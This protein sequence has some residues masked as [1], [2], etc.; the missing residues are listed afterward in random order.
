MADPIKVIF[1]SI[2][3]ESSAKD[4]DYYISEPFEVVLGSPVQLIMT[5]HSEGYR[6]LRFY[7]HR[8]TEVLK[9]EDVRSNLKGIFTRL[10][11]HGVGENS[12]NPAIPNGV[13][14]STNVILGRTPDDKYYDY[15]EICKPGT[16][17][18]FGH[19][20]ENLQITSPDQ[21]TIIELATYPKKK[22]GI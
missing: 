1:D 18:L 19:K 17:Y 16:Y 11:N 9:K 21:P 12:G 5:A 15:I 22:K 3:A 10:H 4:Y 8:T 20:D 7:I 14:S 13:F 6:A 2:K